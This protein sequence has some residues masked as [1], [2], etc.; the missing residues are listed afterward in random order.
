MLY[1][2]INIEIKSKSSNLLPIIETENSFIFCLDY[3]S[4]EME[5][6]YKNL[7]KVDEFLQ[8][9]RQEMI[10]PEKTIASDDM[11]RAYRF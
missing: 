8:D 11:F 5:E 6:S 7:E 1:I 2:E 9:L 3:F 10:N 4:D